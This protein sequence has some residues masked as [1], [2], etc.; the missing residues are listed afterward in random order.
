MARAAAKRRTRESQQ[1]GESQFYENLAKMEAAAS[2][3]AA[4][5]HVAHDLASPTP[6]SHMDKIL[7]SSSDEENSA[8]PQILG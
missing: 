5:A 4:E 1:R 8:V 3:R 2:G 6:V 7:E